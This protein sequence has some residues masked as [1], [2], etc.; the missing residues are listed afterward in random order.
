MRD[1]AGD[2]KHGSAAVVALNIELEGLNLRVLVAHPVDGEVLHN[3]ASGQVGVLAEDSKIES[4]DEANDLQPASERCGEVGAVKG[5]RLR[6]VRKVLREGEVARQANASLGGDD[7]ER[8][9]H[10]E[11]SVLDLNLL[12]AA[13]RL[14]STGQE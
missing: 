3:I 8:G 11:T 10:C 13:V 14:G 12:V 7:A 9:S 2:A 1:H 5:A 6:R 4:S